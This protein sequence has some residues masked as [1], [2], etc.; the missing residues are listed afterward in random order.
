MS[1][2][3][4]IFLSDSSL[5]IRSTRLKYAGSATPGLSGVTPAHSTPRRAPLKPYFASHAASFEVNPAAVFGGAYGAR[6][7]TMLSPCTIT[8]R[9]YWSTRNRPSRCSRGVASDA[10]LAAL[11]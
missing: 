4:Q 9:P 10:A 11:G 1:K 5:V 2:S 6:F 3:V 7:H 8:T